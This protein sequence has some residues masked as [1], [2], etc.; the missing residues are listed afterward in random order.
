MNY[1]KRTHALRSFYLK[2]GESVVANRHMKKKLIKITVLL[3][4]YFYDVSI[5]K[6][7]EEKMFFV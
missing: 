6:N 7:Y 1:K 2:E 3:V 4:Y 5:S